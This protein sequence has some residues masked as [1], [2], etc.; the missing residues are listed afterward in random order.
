M[1]GSFPW[2]VD[3]SSS[4]LGGADLLYAMW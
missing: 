4:M 3:G 2:D 1:S